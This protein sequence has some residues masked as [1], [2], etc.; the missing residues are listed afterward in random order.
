MLEKDVMGDADN[1]NERRKSSFLTSF[2]SNFKVVLES[3]FFSFIFVVILGLWNYSGRPSDCNYFSLLKIKQMINEYSNRHMIR[4]N[5]LIIFP[6]AVLATI[7]QYAMLVLD[8]GYVYVPG[9]LFLTILGTFTILSLIN[10][11]CYMYYYSWTHIR[12]QLSKNI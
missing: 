12:N 8:R 5:I 6:V 1:Y 9:F 4:L 11:I 7:I 2:T 3:F 10:G